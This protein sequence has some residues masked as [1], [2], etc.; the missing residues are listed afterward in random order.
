MSIERKSS[1]FTILLSFFLFF[2]STFAAKKPYIVYL[3][4][5]SHS[6]DEISPLTDEKVTNTHHEI[7]G[8]VL[9]SKEKA[10]D[11]IF[12][13]YTK[14]INGFAAILE[15]DEAMEISKHP[16]VVSVFPS[17]AYKLHTT[18]SWE[19]LG[20]EKDG[21]VPKKSLWTK[22]NF[23]EDVIIGNLD[24]GVW[25]ESESFK[26]DGS[27][28]GRYFN[29]GAIAAGEKINSTFSSPRDTE[30]TDPH[31]LHRRRRAGPRRQ[32]Q[33]FRNGTAKGG[34]PRARVAAYKV[35]W[36]AGMLRHR[37]HGRVRGGDPRRGRRPVG[38]HRGGRSGLL[39]RRDRHRVVP[40]RSGTGTVVA[41]AGSVLDPG[42]A[43]NIAPW[44]ITVGA[45]TMD[46]EFSSYLSINKKHYKGQSM[47]LSSLPGNRFY[48]MITSSDARSA[49]APLN[50]SQLCF[51]GHLD[52]EKVKG[53]IVVCLRGINARVDKGV[54]VK[55]AGGVG[56]VLANDESTGDELIA[57]AHVLPA[58]HPDIT[59]PGV[60]VIASWTEYVSPTDTDARPL[61]YNSESGTS[62][63]CPH[64]SG[65]VGLLKALHPDWSPAAIRSAI[66][67][68]ARVRD[69]V[70]VTTT[71]PRTTT[72]TS[73]APSATT[74][75]VSGLSAS[76]PTRGPSKP[77]RIEDLN[78]L[79][80]R[81]KPLR[82]R[83]TVTVE[84]S[85][86][87]F[88]KV[89]EEKTFEVVLKAKKGL[90]AE[91]AFGRLTWSDG[92]HHVKSPIVVNAKNG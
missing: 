69:N 67:T 31:P 60:S 62:M 52:P 49:D 37:H 83:V 6:K 22:A 82:P 73:Y 77:L 20:L 74:R 46:R 44:L 84:P 70:G 42:S 18:H 29:K 78:Y 86:L 91:Y 75:L 24:T 71:W 11:A 89:G 81:S 12:Y 87:E 9:K 85:T 76:S 65:V 3:G 15:E 48:P 80:S 25:P 54:A 34:S 64:V 61:K 57:D 33:R 27:S 38:V 32:H 28:S 58:V 43:T 53:K 16:G 23:G 2:S 88:S 21:K 36:P 50:T 8:S 17:R 35:C 68:S 1:A 40:R 5:H 39:P 66:M 79:R 7:L 90:T 41:S 30:G 55:Q 4:G 19:F 45:S 47:S 26:D 13:S 72:S 14:Y 56:M 59:A 92:V 51:I 10:K 63:S